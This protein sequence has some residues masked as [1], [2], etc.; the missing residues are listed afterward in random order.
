MNEEELKTIFKILSGGPNGGKIYRP[1]I[2]YL[3]PKNQTD[4]S[5]F[6]FDPKN[7]KNHKRYDITDVPE[8]AKHLNDFRKQNVGVFI[9]NVFGFNHPRYSHNIMFCKELIHTLSVQCMAFHFV[10]NEIIT[11][12]SLLLASNIIPSVAKNVL[13]IIVQENELNVVELGERR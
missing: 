12:T 9:L 4:L 13:I 7:K 8:F 5:L 2:G 1:L 11:L 6:I 3:S 10:T